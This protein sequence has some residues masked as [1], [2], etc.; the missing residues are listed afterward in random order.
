MKNAL[1]GGRQCTQLM[2]SKLTDGKARGTRSPPGLTP[3]G[4]LGEVTSNQVTSH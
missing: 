4:Q 1:R 3:I 2:E